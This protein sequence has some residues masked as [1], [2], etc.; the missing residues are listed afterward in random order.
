MDKILREFYGQDA[1]LGK[2]SKA[3]QQAKFLTWAQ[4]NGY[5]KR[6]EFGT[7]SWIRYIRIG[8]IVMATIYLVSFIPGVPEVFKVAFPFAVILM[9]I[10]MARA[11][12]CPTLIDGQ[13]KPE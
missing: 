1:S 8:G 7:E 10:S 6:L 9:L 2:L 13:N 5:R 3:E 11:G 4:S 12:R